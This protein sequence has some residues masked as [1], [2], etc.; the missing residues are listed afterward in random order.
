MNSE[1][2]GMY[3]CFENQLDFNTRVR[4]V[5]YQDGILYHSAPL[6]ISAEMV[7]DLKAH[8]VDVEYHLLD[9]LKSNTTQYFEM[10]QN[11]I[12]H[13]STQIPELKYVF[14]DMKINE[15]LNQD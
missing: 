15:I 13:A 4:L 1:I 5:K 2:I 6:K 3:S 9:T 14:R 12:D 8:G 11:H 10:N 7:Q